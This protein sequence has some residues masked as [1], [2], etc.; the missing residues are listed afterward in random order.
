MKTGLAVLACMTIAQGAV[1]RGLAADRGAPA[2]AVE[3]VTDSY[4]GVAIRD[5]YRWLEDGGTP[6]V[7]A[8]SMA[9]NSRTRATLDR[10]AVRRTLHDRIM[11]AASQ[12]SPSYHSL[13][14]AGGRLFTLTVQPPKQQPMVT[15]MPPGADP[16][17]ARAVVDP[18]TLDPSGQTAIDWFVPSPD[19]HRVAVSLSRNGS[20]DGTVQVFDVASGKEIGEAVPRAQYPTAGGSLAWKADSSGFWYTR[21][22]GAERPEADRHFFQQVYYHRLGSDP[23]AD[24]YVLG[25]DFPRIAEIQL[26]SRENP[27]AVL[28]SVANGDGGEFEHYVMTADK[29]GA[30]HVTQVTHFADKVV[31]GTIGPDDILYLVSKRDAPRGRI[32]SLPLSDLD[33][34]HARLLV[35]QGDGAI[36]G[37]GEFGGE[38]VAV[39]RDAL[40]L[41]ELVGGP[42]RVAIFAHDG[43]PK[44]EIRLPPVAAVD[45]LEPGVEGHVLYGVQTYLQP[46]HVL[47]YDEASG[48]SAPTG[49]AET[50]PVRFDD[51][52]VVRL[53]ATSKDGT[54]VPVTIIR[55]KGA[56][57][58]GR[59]PTLLYGYGGY[60]VSM[61]PRF[62]GEA[63]RLWLDA[64]GVWAVANIRGGGEYGE[65]WHS[66]GALTHKQHVFDDFLAAGRA[67]IARRITSPSHLAILGG[68]NG[69]LLMGAALTQAPSMFRAVVSLVGIYDMMRIE[70]DPNG[71]FNVTE[72]GSVTDPAQF[73]AMLAYSPY[74]HVRDGVRYPA[75]FMATGTHDGRVN[76]AQSRKM[77]ARLQA[78]TMS[79]YPVYLSISD[80]AGHG[81][82]SALSVRVDQQADYMAFLFDQL[83]MTFSSG[84]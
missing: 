22:P 80:K 19:G 75:V 1:T 70:R 46:Y 35:A 33:L 16:S 15:V 2:T 64:G 69:G 42:S 49:L 71:A 17:Q 74:Q 29:A 34:S 78:A 61:T 32:L 10:L 6:R 77:I 58:D 73:R 25:R 43:T 36:Q 7:A 27:N 48:R 40:Y 13:T 54:R 12:T 38:A 68:S 28:V 31:A 56:S 45:E 20:E 79:G 21:Y 83:G 5:P 57:A 37:G 55:R 59:R 67:L 50:S 65:T 60:E 11:Q 52:E 66:D 47:S 30:Q 3:P 44:G 82:G 24:S 14:M 26:D 63:T 8:W 4:H 18:N 72:F 84:S 76:P 51:A 81:I 41:R 62:A 23:A 53:F 39:T 9:Q